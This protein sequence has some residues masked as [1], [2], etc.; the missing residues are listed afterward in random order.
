VRR[1]V[2]NLWTFCD[3]VLSKKKNGSISGPPG[4]GKSTT[5]WAWACH[6]ALKEGL[7]VTWLHLSL[8]DCKTVINGESGTITSGL[9]AHMDEI[10]D[11]EG[12]L[13]I[14]DGDVKK[15]ASA[16]FKACSNWVNTR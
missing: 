9:I 15:D 2:S 14:V 8:C 13:L 1:E 6:T 10:E 7:T 5:V 3:E 4:T 11:S 12:G 16:I